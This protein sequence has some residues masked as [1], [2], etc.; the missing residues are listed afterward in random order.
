[1]KL[2]SEGSTRGGNF[3]LIADNIVSTA[4]A[5]VEPNTM[6]ATLG[7]QMPLQGWLQDR[8]EDFQLDFF[9][10]YSLYLESLTS[11]SPG[12]FGVL[13]CL[14]PSDGNSFSIA[15][16]SNSF[17]D[18]NS[19]PSPCPSTWCVPNLCWSETFSLFADMF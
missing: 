17:S 6:A 1:L 14:E 12:L 18:M 7:D 2:L 11:R 15:S 19:L 4:V 8:V 13:D 3:K 9:L 16:S 10:P 5:I